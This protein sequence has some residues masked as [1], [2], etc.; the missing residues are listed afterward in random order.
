[1][2]QFVADKFVKEL[3]QKLPDDWSN[4]ISG[5]PQLEVKRFGAADVLHQKTQPSVSTVIGRPA[6][7]VTGMILPAEGAQIFVT[8]VVSANQF[9]GLVSREQRQRMET[10]LNT[11]YSQEGNCQATR[12]KA[13]EELIVGC[14]RCER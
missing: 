5:H 7:N 14:V 6:Q 8:N 2:C 3:G 4:K 13:S 12:L 10:C 11:Y 9:C 1:M